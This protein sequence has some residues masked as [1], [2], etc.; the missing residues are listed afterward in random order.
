MAAGGIVAAMPAPAAPA[1]SPAASGVAAGSD[2]GVAWL[3]RAGLALAAHPRLW[4][5]AVRQVL[6][7]APAGWWRRSPY[8]PLPDRQYLHFRLVTAYGG[9]GGAPR[10]GDVV[11]YLHWCRSWPHVTGR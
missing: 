6:R 10:P 1:P 9:Q 2:V 7:L 4:G 11:T 5:T 8:L 3:V